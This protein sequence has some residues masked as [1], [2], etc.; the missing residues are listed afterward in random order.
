MT[1]EQQQIMFAIGDALRANPMTWNEIPA[2]TRETVIAL[3][4]PSV[5]GFTPEQATFLNWWW[6]KVDTARL[7]QIN[8]NMPP[9]NVV[10]PR[11]DGVGDEFISADL[12]SDAVLPDSR[13]EPV[14]P[15]LL[16]LTLR[17]LP[18]NYWP[19]PPTLP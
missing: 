7:N 9:N 18:A 13:L 4:Q 3:M 19:A 10:A 14:L 16:D 17:Y 6:M 11:V 15:M 12:F 5:T 8:A 1:E 2:E